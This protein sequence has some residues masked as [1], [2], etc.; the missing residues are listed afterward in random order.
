MSRALVVSA[1]LQRS[2]P[3][4][5]DRG[6]RAPLRAGGYPFGGEGPHVKEE[7][8]KRLATLLDRYDEEQLGSTQHAQETQTAQDALRTSFGQLRTAVIRP[9]MEDIGTVL[10]QRGHDYTIV[11]KDASPDAPGTLQDGMIAMYMFPSRSGAPS[12]TRALGHGPHIAF[13]SDPYWRRIIVHTRHVTP[14]YGGLPG[15]QREYAL[16]QMTAALVEQ[17]ILQVVEGM[18]HT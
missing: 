12:T 17:E 8:K 9:L 11:E 16:A 15:E 5:D 2:D 1:V 3:A 13:R 6:K 14:P 18:L 7:T 4:D 10:Q